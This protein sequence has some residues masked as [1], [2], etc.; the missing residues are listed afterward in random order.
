MSEVLNVLVVVDVQDCFM[1]NIL[2]KKEDIQSTEE[3]TANVVSNVDDEEPAN[4]EEPAKKTPSK[5]IPSYMRLTENRKNYEKQRQ[6]GGEGEEIGNLLNF[7]TTS[8][9][10]NKIKL[11]S[12]MVKTIADLAPKNDIVIF[13]R[14]MH[15]KN[16][17]SFEGDEGRVINYSSV[18]PHHC[19]TEK[20]CGSRMPDTKG[21]KIGAPG[22]KPEKTIKDVLDEAKS[23]GVF[24]E[25]EEGGIGSYGLLQYPKEEMVIRGNQLSYFFYFTS[26]ANTVK[27]L[28]D[29]ETAISL[30]TDQEEGAPN[31][32]Q[33]NTDITPIKDES[34]P[35]TEYYSLWKGERCDYESYSA[36]NYHLAYNVE[37]YDGEG[38]TGKQTKIPI[39]DTNKNATEYKYTTGLFEFIIQKVNANPTIKTINFNICGLV[40]D[41]CVMHSAIQGSLLWEKIYKSM[42]PE[43]TTCNFNVELAATAFLGFYAGKQTAP[44]YF[45]DTNDYKPVKISDGTLLYPDLSGRP[46][47]LQEYKD[48]YKNE[49][50]GYV[51]DTTQASYNFVLNGID[52]SPTQAGGRKRTRRNRKFSMHKKHKQNC[53]CKFCLY[54]GGKRKSMKKRR[55]T[56]KRRQRK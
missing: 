3:Q 39:D 29:S 16:H 56:K 27:K 30:K 47:A 7:G 36:F 18:W 28:N 53:N 49:E 20:E 10:A 32:G 48:F 19:R 42:L 14:D 5:E 41:V 6:R 52:Q 25:S 44:G 54:G 38:N 35:N 9:V 15:P 33:I 17:I 21:T 13:T 26:L 50:N 45:E 43:V 24:I 11:S 4:I 23:E 55:Q 1:S 8:G 22:A 51:A 40:G 46:A 31:Y 34:N 2:T 12:K 37:G